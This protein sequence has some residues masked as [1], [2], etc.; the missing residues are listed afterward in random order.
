MTMTGVSLRVSGAWCLL[1][2]NRVVHADA[3]TFAMAL[4]VTQHVPPQTSPKTPLS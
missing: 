3:P 1:Q 4:N 2:P